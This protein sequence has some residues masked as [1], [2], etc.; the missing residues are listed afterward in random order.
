V[1][2]CLVTPQLLHLGDGAEPLGEEQVCSGFRFSQGKRR[3]LGRLVVGGVRQGFGRHPEF[4]EER[5]SRVAHRPLL[6]VTDDLA[7]RVLPGGAEA[8]LP[9]VEERTAGCYGLLVVEP[10][11]VSELAPEGG[12]FPLVEFPR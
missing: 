1:V 4:V 9:S 12:P 2:W 11:E 6:L 10:V 8:L 7:Y 5:A 3:R